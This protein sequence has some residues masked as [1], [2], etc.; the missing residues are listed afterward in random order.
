[1]V[2][3]ILALLLGLTGISGHC[4]EKAPVFFI[5]VDGIINPPIAKYIIESIERAA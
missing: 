5:E 4:E 2:A 1:M 3:L